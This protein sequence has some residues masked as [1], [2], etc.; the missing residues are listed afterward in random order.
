[1]KKLALVL[2]GRNFLQDNLT[3]ITLI[4]IKICSEG[5]QKSEFLNIYDGNAMTYF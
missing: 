4:I 3:I 1:M 2:S 5:T